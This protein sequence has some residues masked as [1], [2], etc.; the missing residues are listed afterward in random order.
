MPRKA[1]LFLLLGLPAG[2]Q[3]AFVATGNTMH[4]DTASPTSNNAIINSGTNTV[5]IA[6]VAFDKA[7]GASVSSVTYNSVAMTSAGSAALNGTSEAYAQLFYLVNPPTGTHVFAVTTSGTVNDI[8]SLLEEY[9][10]VDQTNPVRSGSYNTSTTSAITIT[11]NANDKSTTCLNSGPGSATST[12]QT[13]I[14]SNSGGNYGA[15]AD[16]ATTGAASVT[17]TWSTPTNP[18]LAGLSVCNS[19][20]GCSGG[21]LYTVATTDA[22]AMLDAGAGLGTHFGAAAA[23]IAALR[24]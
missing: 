15:G 8:Y 24:A 18:A 22:V 3:V 14:S 13:K 4:N 10:G 6:C 1:F 11:S 23:P 7:S 19:G 20:G 2:A 12:T 17:H 9:S 16:Y 5:A 21:S